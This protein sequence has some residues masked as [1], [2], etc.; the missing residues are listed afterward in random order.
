MVLMVKVGSGLVRKSSRIFPTGRPG[1]AGPGRDRR[2]LAARP[3]VA[4][5]HQLFGLQGA[6]R[7]KRIRTTVRDQGHERAADLLRRDFTAARLS[8]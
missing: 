6:R 2:G 4:A 7:G 1:W 8:T 5:V 3:H